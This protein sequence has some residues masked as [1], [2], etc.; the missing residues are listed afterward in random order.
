MPDEGR[1]QRR[2]PA[3]A[4]RSPNP[5]HRKRFRF[6]VRPVYDIRMGWDGWPYVRGRDQGDPSDCREGG[7]RSMA[8]CRSAPFFGRLF[9]AART[10][11]AAEEVSTRAGA[12]RNERRRWRG[13]RGKTG[14]RPFQ[15][16][17]AA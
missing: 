6:F 14:R 9:I 12:A 10:A 11:T 1:T 8:A 17:R 7:M 2:D 5:D 16:G 3:A 15:R 4:L 13:P